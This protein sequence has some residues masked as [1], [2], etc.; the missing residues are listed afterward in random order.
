MVRPPS[1]NPTELE[2][3]ILKI[4]WRCGPLSVRQVRQ[5]LAAGPSLRRL[6]HTSVITM[7]NIMVRK[8]YLRRVA[9]GKGYIFHPRVQEQEVSRGMLHDLVE[10]LFE[11]STTAAMLQLLETSDLDEREIEKLRKLIGRQAKES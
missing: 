1:G 8:S 5:E 10:R 3:E 4:L 7:L 9:Q 6:A 11:G 2:L